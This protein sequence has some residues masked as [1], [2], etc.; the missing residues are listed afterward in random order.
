MAVQRNS[1]L[2]F[3]AG[4]ALSEFRRVKISPDKKVYYADAAEAGVGVTQNPISAAELAAGVAVAVRFDTEG[5]SKMTAS[6]AISAG[7][8]VYA[9]A[10]GKIAP[11]GTVLIGNAVDA[12]TADGS[13]IE[14]APTMG[15]LQSSSSSS[16]SSST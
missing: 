9:A 3:V 5:T 10:D 8:K 6:A 7:A 15:R 2:S 1:P 11:T 14:I 13:V 16:S 12:A 4:E